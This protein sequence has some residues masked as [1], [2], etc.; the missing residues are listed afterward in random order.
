MGKF[1]LKYDIQNGMH[2]IESAIL[3][4]MESIPAAILF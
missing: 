1:G 3:M 2:R 4:G